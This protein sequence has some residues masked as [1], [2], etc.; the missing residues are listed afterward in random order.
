MFYDVYFR[1]CSEKGVKPSVA[2]ETCGIARSSVSTW[3]SVGNTPRSEILNTLANYF[4]V[5]VDY[6]V[7]QSKFPRVEKW[8]PD[9][10][11]DYSNAKN[12]QER[13]H[14]LE[15]FGVTPEHQRDLDRLSPPKKKPA[16]AGEQTI[17]DED[18]MFA[19]WGDTTEVSKEDLE[20]V[21]RYAAF[22]RDRKKKHD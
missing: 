8:M 16:Q 21:K 11:E 13:L 19:L 20:D 9:Q 7:F 17:S 4:G 12:D 15:L 14:M 3:K 10:E 5:S 6:L 18:I 2:A 1:L 22:I